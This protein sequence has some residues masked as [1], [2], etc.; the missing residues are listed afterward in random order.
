MGKV[1]HYAGK[2]RLTF[3]GNFGRMWV[4]CLTVS[5]VGMSCPEL[6]KIRA[7]WDLWNSG[8][9]LRGANVWMK[10]I[11]PEFDGDS[12]GDQALGPPYGLGDFQRLRQ[13]GANYVNFSV[14]GIFS[15][16]PPYR[17]LPEV[18]SELQALVRLAERADLFVV[19]SFRTGPGR[20]EAGFDSSESAR[21]LH[22]VWKSPEAQA[23]WVS[24]WEKAARSFQ[25]FP[26][27]I[28]FD[29]M[30]EPNANDVW[31]KIWEPGDFFARYRN[32]LYDWT[33]LARRIVAAIRSVDGQT[34]ILIGGM[35]YSSLDWLSEVPDLGQKTVG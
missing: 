8:T 18:L 14:P 19:L 33:P 21:A 4:T 22:E 28:G 32:S 34:P 13:M 9:C 23:A 31:L 1:N 29:L 2:L 26:N 15:E 10:V 30:V 11:E 20:N 3:I 25:G 17:F 16:R 5:S 7:P 6:S 35:N 12:L 27:L 24:M